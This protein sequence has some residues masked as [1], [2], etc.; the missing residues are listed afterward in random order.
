MVAKRKGKSKVVRSILDKHGE[1]VVIE[2]LKKFNGY[3]HPAAKALGVDRSTL[4]KWMDKHPATR[5]AIEDSLEI[6]LD[7]A[8]SKLDAAI[9]QGEAWATCFFLK[10]KGQKR[11]Y[12]EKHQ[13]D[14][15]GEVAHVNVI[16]L[17]D[18][19][20]KVQQVMESR[21]IDRSAV[22]TSNLI[23]TGSAGQET[24]NNPQSEGVTT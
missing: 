15:S 14:V 12:I 24:I 7:V 8:E 21:A 3:L 18:R 5:A 2:Q 22:V 23:G 9:N 1:A 13:L 16:D 11:G 10:C 20:K 19:I 17:E 4:S 6:R